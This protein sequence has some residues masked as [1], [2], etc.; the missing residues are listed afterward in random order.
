MANK[1]RFNK[2]AAL[3]ICISLLGCNHWDEINETIK[4]QEKVNV[5]ST[6]DVVT[7]TT[8]ATVDIGNKSFTKTVES[9][10]INQ[11]LEKFVAFDPNAQGLYP[12]A[13]VQGKGL[14]NGLLL[15]VTTKR[16]P[17]TITV[18]DFYSDTSLS[19]SRTINNPELSVVN[20]SIHSIIRQGF[21][22]EQP[23]KLTFAESQLYSIEQA[24]FNLDA[25]Y[26]WAAGKVDGSFSMSNDKSL[27]RFLVR[28]V[29]K[30]F[31]VSCKS[32]SAPAS[33]ISKKASIEDLNNY[34]QP[35]NGKPN[36]LTYVASVT[37]GRELWMLIESSA[38]SN[39][40]EAALNASYG[41]IGTS[42]EIHMTKEDSTLI[43]NSSIQVLIM[44]GGTKPA[45][46][47]L[48]GDKI[49]NINKF[50]SSGDSFNKK[51]PG[52]PISYSVHYLKDNDIAA[53]KSTTDYEINTMKGLPSPLISTYVHFH[54]GDDGKS[55]RTGLTV[56]LYNS[57]QSLVA[58]GGLFDNND[59]GVEF[60]DDG[61]NDLPLEIK[62]ATKSDK[63]KSGKV[64][65]SMVHH[66][67][68]TWKIKEM[69]LVMIFKD[70]TTLRQP[71]INGETKL[72]E[73]NPSG[74]F[75]FQIN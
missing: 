48:Q 64:V 57:D 49:N 16:T 24:F 45:I 70:G 72:Y 1:S 3:L 41:K 69:E 7:G 68:D 36:P 4:K 32:P 59:Q 40:L 52:I 44:G 28:F 39:K 5:P 51:N 18:A 62:A 53:V 35:E 15:E 54:S 46:E 23:A 34:M 55:K 27:S 20:D 29:Q 63:L 22:T 9:H 12:G 47:F 11:R 43:Q 37:Y 56:Q 67:H 13:L 65:V 25:S 19:F 38:E 33:F 8:D 10:K 14:E 71:L 30:Y 58:Q 74:E 17:I 61:T 6:T 2:L 26:S 73:N 21:N 60:D 66:G 42:A 75:H 50:L 31:T